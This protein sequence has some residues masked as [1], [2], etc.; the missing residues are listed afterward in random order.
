MLDI[1]ATLYVSPLS[2]VEFTDVPLTVR[3]VNF[4]DETGYVTGRF[5]IYNDTTGELIFDSLIE[6]LTIAA[7]L[8]V[9]VSA[10]TDFSPP[11]PLDDTY[12][13][14][15]DGNASSPLVPR[16][17]SFSLCAFYFDVKPGPLG[18]PPAAHAPTHEQAGADPIET[19]DLGT[20]ELDT[21]LSLAPDGVGGVAWNFRRII[22]LTVSIVS[23]ATPTPDADSADQFNITA[24]AA[25]ATF[26]APTGS[27]VDGQKLIIRILDDGTPRA[28]SWNAIYVPRGAAL[29][30]TTIVSKY[31]YCLFVR[32][33]AAVKWDCVAVAAEA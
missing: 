7:G 25:A 32:N 16:G 12:F 26:G 33:S 14:L 30:A 19:A 23:S 9:D 15:F 31:L 4:A 24:L 8:S 21:T 2:E 20:A 1:R 10:L 5:R 18:A 27:P 6:P 13:V 22:P 28:L 3:L 17:V 11:A 29:P